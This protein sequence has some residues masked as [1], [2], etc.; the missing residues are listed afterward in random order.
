M[1]NLL[2]RGVG[3]AMAMSLSAAVAAAPFGAATV[4]AEINRMVPADCFLLGYSG[5]LQKMQQ[6]MVATVTDVEP[7]M[8]MMVA[9]AGPSTMLNM[10]VRKENGGMGSGGVKIDG[11]AA[12]FVG[13]ADAETGDPLSGIIFEVADADG[14]VSSQP[15]MVLTRLPETNWVCLSNRAYTLPTSPSTMG[16]G[17]VNATLAASF[18][19][20]KAI[21]E[22][23]SQIDGLLAMMQKPLPKG[24]LPPEQE[25]MIARSQAANVAKMKMFMDMISV[26]DLGIDLNGAD[27]DILARIVPTDKAFVSTGTPALKELSRLVPADMPIAGVMNHGVISMMMEMSKSDIEQFPPAAQ[28]KLEA[29]MPVWT[30]C[31]ETMKSGVAFGVSLGSKGLDVVQVMDTDDP[32]ASLAAIQRGWTALLA[33]DLGVNAT[34]IE[35]LRG[36]GIGYSIKIDAKQLMDTIGMSDMMPPVAAGQPDPMAMVQGMIDDVMSSDGMPV[37]YLIEGNYILTVMGNAKLAS[38]RA[39]VSAGGSDNAVSAVLAE[40]LAPP[41]FAMAVDIREAINGGMGFARAIMGPMG[42]MLPL[43]APAGGPVMVTAVGSTEGTTWDQIRIKTNV[44][45]WYA[46]I[47][48]FQAAFQPPSRPIAK[49]QANEGM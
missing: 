16:N 20:V 4:P 30:S 8:A 27:L 7:Q 34:P 28:A 41:T 32:E 17:M 23:K 46:M 18:D 24:I 1:K 36:K 47:Q 6:A 45:D 22:F 39:L 40:T 10:M 19:Q 35:I 14:L 42:A 38:A 13:G 26:W 25:A 3:L 33:T 48:Q 2:I 12:V 15:T 43:A 31:L 21:K 29:L 5:S 37:R 9:M 49:V 44:K 11:A